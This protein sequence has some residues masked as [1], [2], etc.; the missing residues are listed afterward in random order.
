MKKLSTNII[1]LDH[2]SI[3]ESVKIKD[4]KGAY[5]F[6]DKINIDLFLKYDWSQ[7]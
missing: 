4:S 6:V 1:K 3:V 2:A 5:K 7:V